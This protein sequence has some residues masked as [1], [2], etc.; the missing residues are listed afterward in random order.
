MKKVLIIGIIL[1]SVFVGWLVLKPKCV[2]IIDE[3]GDEYKLKEGETITID[4]GKIKIMDIQLDKV[5]VKKD[6]RF[7]EYKYDKEY[8]IYAPAI[9]FDDGS[10]LS[11]GFAPI[12]CIIFKKVIF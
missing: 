4:A 3:N 5:V 9:E 12:D 8:Q 6:G 1:G 2:K 7:V 11:G 10:W